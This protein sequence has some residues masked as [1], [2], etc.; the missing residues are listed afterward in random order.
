MNRKDVF[1]FSDYRSFLKTYG[2]ES[3]RARAGWSYSV[4]ARRLGLA[5][6]APLTMVINGQRQAGPKLIRSLVEYFKFAGKEREYFLD[7]VRLQKTRND[8]GLRMHL[9]QKIQKN[10]AAK[11]FKLLDLDAFTAISKWNHYAIREMIHLNDFQDDPDWIAKKLRFK[12]TPREV[13]SAITTLL[14][15][16]LLKRDQGG[17]LCMSVSG[18]ETSNDV[19]CEGL[20]RFHEEMI[21]HAKS[22]IRSVPLPHREI[23]GV[24]LTIS[25]RDLERAKLMLRAFQDEF[26]AAFEA[27]SGDATYQLNFQLFPLTQGEYS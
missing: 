9:L 8:P 21:D 1:K 14:R 25:S 23:S 15:T 3:K 24:T 17:R 2:E 13:K 7:L 18:I 11:D 6:T 19:A 10:S 26:V 12:Q 22:A 4:W 27:K 16:G 5:G 20:K